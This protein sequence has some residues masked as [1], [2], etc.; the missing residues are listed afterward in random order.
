MNYLLENSVHYNEESRALEN[1]NTE[2]I[3]PV[4]AARLLSLLL[5]KNNEQLSRNE[6]LEKV[7]EQYGLVAS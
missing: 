7:W 2:I 1:D 4:S 5:Q 3:L 6:I